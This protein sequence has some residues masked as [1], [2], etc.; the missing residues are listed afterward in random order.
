[1]TATDKA[2]GLSPE[3]RAGIFHFTV[4]GSVGVASAY[5][6]IWLTNQ[7]ITPDEVG[8]INAAPVLVMLAINILVGRLADKAQ[9]W[10]QM[11]IIL[12]LLAGAVPIGL[13]FVNGFWGILMLWTLAMV[14]ATALVPVV[15]AAT[16][17]MTQRRGTD[18]GA[19]RAW[20][21]IGYTL[22]T[23]SA[24]PIIAIFGEPAFLPLFLAWSMFRGLASLQLPRFRAAPGETSLPTVEGVRTRHLREVLRP[25]FILPLIGLAM[26]YGNHVVLHSFGALLWNEQ[27][28]SEALIG[29]LIAAMAAAE[30]TMM[31]LWRRLNRRIS[32]RHLII[33][34]AVVGAARWGVM[35][36]EPPVWLLFGLQ[37][38]HAVTFALAYL[39]G[40]YFIANWTS[41]DIAAEAQSFSVMLQQGFIV[42]TLIAF[43]WLAARFGA[44]AWLLPAALS[45]TGA[46]LVWISLRMQPTAASDAKE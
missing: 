17:R 19:V 13:W 8:L 39:G 20:G 32:A 7:G 11:I 41:E 16:L 45:A 30:A 33:I 40:I 21:T 35:S 18:F 46:L 23:A 42:L 24:G 1:M 43:G 22:T 3:V 2:P 36:L 15:D 4:F 9:D 28:I 14:P 29:P 12:S 27:G 34:A 44:Q 38:L 31:F 5:F 6:G 10:R 25:W 26:H 37:L